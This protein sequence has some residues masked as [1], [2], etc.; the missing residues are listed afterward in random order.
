MFQSRQL[1]AIMFPDIV[2]YLSANKIYE[3]PQIFKFRHHNFHIT[4]SLKY[5]L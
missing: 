2:G 4:Y 5:L 1:A 3:L